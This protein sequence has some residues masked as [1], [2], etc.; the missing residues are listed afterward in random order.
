MWIT[1]T[2]SLK[3]HERNARYNGHGTHENSLGREAVPG[4]GFVSRKFCLSVFCSLLQSE[5]HHSPHCLDKYIQVMGSST[6]SESFVT[7]LV[8]S[9]DELN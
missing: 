4:V 2:G 5:A 3:G 9:L 1:K 7:K 6:K 8:P